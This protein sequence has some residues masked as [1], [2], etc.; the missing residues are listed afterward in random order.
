M[1]VWSALTASCLLHVGATRADTPADASFFKRQP[2]SEEYVPIQ[3]A[4]FDDD[5]CIRAKGFASD[6]E[7]STEIAIYDASGRE[8]GR[9]LKTVVAKGATWRTSVCLVPTP[10]VDAP[11][12]WWFV[13]TLDDVPVVS[14]S[15]QV[16]YGK[17]KPA[18]PANSAKKPAPPTRAAHP[19]R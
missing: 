12:E 3:E 6:G 2:N 15:M 17:P 14:K 19:R 10:D 1:K 9:F 13:I 8:F 11:G 16:K 5:I 4:T 18:P 7:H